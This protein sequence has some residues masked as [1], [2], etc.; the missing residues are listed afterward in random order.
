MEP[1]NYRYEQPEHSTAP[2]GLLN[3]PPP[4]IRSLAPPPTSYSLSN[5]SQK[6]AMKLNSRKFFPYFLTK[7]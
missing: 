2:D 3:I 7:I 4:E 6:I 1:Y 5:I